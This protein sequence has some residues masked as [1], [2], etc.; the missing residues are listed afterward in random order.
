MSEHGGETG[1]FDW[2]GT[3]GLTS[4]SEEIKEKLAAPWWRSGQ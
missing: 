3:E 1:R 4:L 2:K